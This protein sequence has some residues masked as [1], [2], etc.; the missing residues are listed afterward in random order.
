MNDRKTHKP[1]KKL[2]KAEL[3]VRIVHRYYLS[4]LSVIRT[5]QA[6]LPYSSPVR[7]NLAN[8]TSHHMIPYRITKNARFLRRFTF[9]M[10]L[11]ILYIVKTFTNKD[12]AKAAFPGRRDLSWKANMTSWSKSDRWR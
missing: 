2:G 1:H 10:A 5:R 4:I 9:F 3:V 11:F 12:N 6:Y 7:L 8:K